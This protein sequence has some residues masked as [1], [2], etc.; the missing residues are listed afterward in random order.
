MQQPAAT[1]NGE[2]TTILAP[3]HLPT[4]QQAERLANGETPEDG[5][6]LCEQVLAAAPGLPEAL[7]LRGLILGKLNRLDEAGADLRAAI[8]IR[9]NVPHWH[10]G[11]RDVYRRMYRM[12]DALASAR[13]AVRIDPGNARWRAPLA[14]ILVD[15]DETEAARAVLL[16]ALALAPDDVESHLALAHILL[17]EGDYAPGWREYEWRFRGEAHRKAL[18]PLRRPFWNGMALPGRRILLGADQGF[19]DAFQFARFIPW[20]ADR[21]AGVVVL[22]REPQLRLFAAIPGVEACVTD[23]NR[24]GPHAAYCWLGSLPGLL[25]TLPQTIPSAPYLPVDPLRRVT[26]RQR[27]AGLGG[28]RVGLCWQGNPVNTADWRRSVP[29]GLLQGLAAIP[30]VSLVSL[31]VPAGKADGA[32]MAGMGLFD[33]T[34]DLSDFAETAALIA[35]LD[36]VISVDSAIAHLAGGLGIPTWILLYHPS[37]WRWMRGRTDTPWYPSAR[38]FRQAVAGE[39]TNVAGEVE[40]ALRMIAPA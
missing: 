3:I 30:G 34:A 20:V 37:D 21:C 8:A 6:A 4:L 28:L 33:A 29:L 7:A 11:L 17:A 19:G 2:Y 32:V 27:L 38:L 13:E 35:N 18:P 24:A 26:W 36:L 14:H 22:C 23:I 12:D 25:G 16:D 39:W 10:H 5:L 9:A 31:Q 1:V 15:R 40:A